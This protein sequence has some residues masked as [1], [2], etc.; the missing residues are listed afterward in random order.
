MKISK[1]NNNKIYFNNGKLSIR[2]KKRVNNRILLNHIGGNPYQSVITLNELT[3]SAQKFWEEKKEEGLDEKWY[4]LAINKWSN[5]PASVSGVLDGY[6]D[7]SAPDLKESA[8]F[9]DFL[10]NKYGKHTNK[11]IIGMA[12]L[13]ALDCGAGI[14]RIT[15]GILMQRFDIIDLVEPVTHFIDKAKLNLSKIGHV[16]NFYDT[17]LQN[18]NS[19]NTYDCIWIQWVL[20]QLTDEDVITFLQKCKHM[21]TENGVIVVKENMAIS[22][23]SVDNNYNLITRNYKDTIRLFKLSGL[24][25]LHEQFQKDF[26]TYLQKVNMFALN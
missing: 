24:T 3:S 8:I 9:L 10:A 11:D 18:F 14:G 17:S 16:G 25:L 13:R 20:G 7:A 15:E 22:G 19:S 5:K 21:L 12:G 4:N 6:E 2:R 26:P 23:F 1:K